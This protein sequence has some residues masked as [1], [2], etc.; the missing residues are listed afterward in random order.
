M[1]VLVV[2]V[3]LGVGISIILRVEGVSEVVKMLTRW[4]QGCWVDWNNGL[5]LGMGCFHMLLQV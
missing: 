2:V 4:L 5:G 1:V 3:V